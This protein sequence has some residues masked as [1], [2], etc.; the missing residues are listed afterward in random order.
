MFK[1]KQKDEQ[2]LARQGGGGGATQGCQR[3]GL[4]PEVMR[5]ARARPEIFL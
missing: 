5:T 2:E 3:R 1:L 4:T